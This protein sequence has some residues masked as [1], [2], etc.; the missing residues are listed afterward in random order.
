[1][2]ANFWD[3][4]AAI[5]YDAL[6][7]LLPYEELQQTI[8]DA[9]ALRADDQLFVA[10]CGTGNMEWRA[11]QRFPDLRVEAMD[12]STGMLA[13]AQAKCADR[14]QVH[15]Q[16][17]DL[18]QPLP[19]PDGAFSVA[20]MCNV[21]YALPDGEAALREIFRV[22]RPGGRLV[23]CDR[24][25][26]SSLRE[27]GRRHFATLRTLPAGPRYG[28]LA[29]TITAFPALLGVVCANQGIRKQHDEG[30][31]HLYTVEAITSRLQAL[32][33]AITATATAYADQCWLVQAQH[34][35][36]GAPM[37]TCP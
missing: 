33:F 18:C 24:H 14:P 23:L 11:T 5:G 15:H 26:W 10:G 4:Y 13:R 27:V 22:L 9:A 20:V 8:V 19:F 25:P 2:A 6:Q 17:G 30:A 36:A 34:P 21:L 32:G 31:Y 16:Q 7:V 35:A 29:R 12:F 3:R 37:E 1:M 28:R